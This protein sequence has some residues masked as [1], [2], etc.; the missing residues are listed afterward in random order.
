[1]KV[2]FA[3]V[4]TLDKGTFTLNIDREMAAKIL[5]VL[6]SEATEA[7]KER[8]LSLAQDAILS[9]EELNDA[10]KEVKTDER[11]DSE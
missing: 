3:V 4:R 1:M 2:C 5:D 6:W 9:I 7:T 11:T 8:N 10:L